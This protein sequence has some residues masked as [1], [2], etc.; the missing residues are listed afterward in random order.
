MATL[1]ATPHCPKC[2]GRQ[3]VLD[4]GYF[5]KFEIQVNAINRAG[6]SELHILELTP[7]SMRRLL[8][9]LEDSKND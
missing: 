9:I 6:K 5:H 8:T 4:T 1:L 7:R 3:I 2:D